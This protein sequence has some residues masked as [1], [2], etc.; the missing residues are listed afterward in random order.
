M[1]LR[2]SDSLRVLT[3]PSLCGLQEV[4]EPRSVGFFGCPDLSLPVRSPVGE[5]ASVGRILRSDSLR[6]LICT[7]LC[8]LQLVSGPRSVGLFACPD[9]S[10]P[11]WS[12]GSEW[13]SVG[14]TLSVT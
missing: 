1:G 4:S 12:P 14:R 11:V 2:R 7:S 5:W 13:A 8:G 10:L 3:C 9:L 6:V